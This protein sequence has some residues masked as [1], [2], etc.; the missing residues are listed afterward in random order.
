MPGAGGAAP[1][2]CDNLC[3]R[4]MKCT[5]AAST[6]VT[7]TVLAP[8]PARFG[9]ADPLYNAVVYVP[10]APVQPFKP[11]VSCERCGA[12]ISGQP[13]VTTL[14]GPDGR[15]TLDNVP[16]GANVPLVIQIGRWRRQVT[17]PQVNPCETTTLPAELTRL[18]RNKSEGD[19]PLMAIAT[20]M[21]DP[22]ECLLR[23]IGVEDAEFTVPTGTGRVH[24]FAYGGLKLG[25]TTPAGDQLTNSL[26]TLDK[27]DVVLLPCDDAF[28]KLPEEQKNLADYSG[29]GGR[30]FLT[31]WS[32]SW[33]NDMGPFASRATWRD[34]SRRRRRDVHR[35]GRSDVPQG[36]GARRVAGRGQGLRAGVRSGH[37][38]RPLRRR[39][40]VPGR[41]R[42]HPA[43][44]L[45]RQARQRRGG[46]LVQHAGRRRGRLAVRARRLQHVPRRRRAEGGQLPGGLRGGPADPAREGARVHAVRRRLLRAARQG[47]TERLPPA[48]AAAARPAAEESTSGGAGT[49]AQAREPA[50]EA[51]LRCRP[52][53][54]ASR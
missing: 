54:P 41:H 6:R 40:L 10:N 52:T 34:D 49:A 50:D 45:H 46:L 1:V 5:G 38:P 22:V 51:G 47:A 23:K 25:K 27:Y 20:G 37:H 13:L 28:D 14:S 35:E 30:I 21:W 16:T 8:T 17:I 53:C 4:Q 12:E 33:L 39:L 7:G 42:P 32:Y 43:L 19:I 11:G 48:P 3:K 36:Q 24:M 18:P 31:D 29:R 15:F 2:T 9:A 44:A 26:P